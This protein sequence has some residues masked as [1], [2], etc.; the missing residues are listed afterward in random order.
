MKVMNPFHILFTMEVARAG[1][2]AS[3]IRL[4]RLL[5]VMES[6]TNAAHLFQHTHRSPRKQG[7]RVLEQ[8]KQL[9]FVCYI[10][11]NRHFTDCSLWSK[12]LSRHVSGTRQ[13]EPQIRTCHLET[14]FAFQAKENLHVNISMKR[15]Y[16][17][18]N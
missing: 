9:P 6:C 14:K 13:N 11:C 16:T 5:E 1:W 8:N 12:Y 15:A 3:M 4:E 18:E 10:S 17:V 7:L 2:D